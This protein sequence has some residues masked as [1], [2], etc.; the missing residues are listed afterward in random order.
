MTELVFVMVAEMG[1]SAL[2][3]VVC[4]QRIKGFAG[5]IVGVVLSTGIFLLLQLSGVTIY[6]LAAIAKLE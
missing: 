6:I 4:L 3:L 5:L 2:A 1:F